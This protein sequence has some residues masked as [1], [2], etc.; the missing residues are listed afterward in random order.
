MPFSPL[1]T[2]EAEAIAD[3]AR[4]YGAFLGMSVVVA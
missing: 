2:F 4:R 1:S 3:A